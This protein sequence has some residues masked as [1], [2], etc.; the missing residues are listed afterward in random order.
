MHRVAKQIVRTNKDVA[1]P[2]CIREEDDSLVTGEADVEERWEI[3]LK[4]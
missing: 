4:S 3:I 2:G 1:G